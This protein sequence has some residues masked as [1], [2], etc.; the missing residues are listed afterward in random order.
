MSPFTPHLCHTLWQAM[1]GEENILQTPWPE[2][3]EDALV[4]SSIDMVIQ[5]NGKLRSKISIDASMDRDMIQQMALADEKIQ[6]FITDLTVR[7]VIVVPN[8]LINI[9]FS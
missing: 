6:N 9:V 7:K 5:V 3:D 1:T 8:K 4:K 2:V